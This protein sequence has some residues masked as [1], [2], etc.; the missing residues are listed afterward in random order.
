MSA[1]AAVS[2]FPRKEICLRSLWSAGCRLCYFDYTSTKFLLVDRRS[3]L[4]CFLVFV[5]SINQKILLFTVAL[6]LQTRGKNVSKRFLLFSS[7]TCLLH[8]PFSVN[9]NAANASLKGHYHKQFCGY[10]IVTHFYTLCD[11]TS[12]TKSQRYRWACHDTI[13]KMLAV[14]FKTPSISKTI[15]VKKWRAINIACKTATQKCFKKRLFISQFSKKNKM[16]TEFDLS[17]AYWK[18]NQKSNRRNDFS[19][20][21]NI[22]FRFRKSFQKRLETELHST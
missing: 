15:F 16:A 1:M 18:T 21:L 10:Y 20:T 3:L 14:K 9:Y 2:P 17:V 19:A 4:R 12:I 11:W 13:A 8:Q 7:T 6:N 5:S 22:K